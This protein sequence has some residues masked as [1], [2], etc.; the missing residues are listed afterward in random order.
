[1]NA[2][3]SR[4]IEALVATWSTVIRSAAR[5]FGLSAS[6]LD[7]VTQDVRLRVWKHFE[8]EPNATLNASYGYR[9][10]TSAA[11]DLVR[12]ERSRA[13]TSTDELVASPGADE[14]LLDR[15][16]SA[17]AQLPVSRRTPVRL[18]LDGRSLAEIAR[19]LQWTEAQARNQVYRGL[20]DLKELLTR[21][22]DDSH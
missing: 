20:A 18:H 13:T 22:A 15:L 17:I 14:R 6:D 12:R 1:M 19:V 4:D 11:I 7:E 21:H 3:L 5:R 9:A 2:R 8:R 10:A 16:A